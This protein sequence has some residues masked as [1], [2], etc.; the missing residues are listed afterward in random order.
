MKVHTAIVRPLIESDSQTARYQWQCL[1]HCMQS[2]GS[3]QSGTADD[4]SSQLQGKPAW[5]LLAASDVV[6]SRIQVPHQ[7]QK[8]LSQFLAFEIEPQ[9]ACDISQLHIAGRVIAGEEVAV[10]HV[11]RSLLV[12]YL[13]DLESSGVAVEHCYSEGHLLSAMDSHWLLIVDP[14]TD[15]LTCCWGAGRYC[16]VKTS[17]AR[18]LLDALLESQPGPD[19]LTVLAAEQKDADALRGNLESVL[20]EQMDI[21]VQLGEHLHWQWLSLA[22]R[23]QG[24]DLRQG[25]FQAP[26]RWGRKVGWLKVPA[27]AASLALATYLAATALAV[28]QGNRQL[29][30]LQVAIEDSYRQAM[31]QGVLVDAAQQLR[32]Q[33]AQLTGQESGPGLLL[34][35]DQV[36]PALEKV[37]GVRVQRLNY[38]AARQE[39]NLSVSAVSNED[40]LSLN[41]A[42]GEAGLNARTQNISRQ[43]ESHLAQLVIFSSGAAS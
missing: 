7:Q 1:D 2:T 30:A 31:P 29:D 15:A 43:G 5:L 41:E 13:D 8:Q 40:I 14:D 33:L 35:L 39:L 16:T 32:S 11:D 17:Q 10:A 24:V 4:L 12:R 42:L 18:W 26:V 37:S 23:D 27:I 34:I 38:S 25:E 36:A 21:S 9:L 20:A 22:Q 6:D 3:V 28:Y 19:K